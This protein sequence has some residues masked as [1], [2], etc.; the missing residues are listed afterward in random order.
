VMLVDQSPIGRTPRSNPATYVKVFDEIRRLFSSTRDAKRHNLN[1]SSFSFN[2]SG[3]RC[4]HCEG[5]GYNRV[6]MQFLAD[7]YVTCDKCNGKRFN[8]RVLDVKYKNKNINEILEMTVDEA[9]SFFHDSVRITKGL[10]FLQETGLGYLRL[11]QPATTLSG[12]EAQRL[13]IAAYMAQESADEMLFIFDEPTV[14]L[15]MDDIQKLLTC[16]QKLVEGRHSLIVVEHN[17]DIIKSADYIIDLGP[18]GGDA[19]GYIVGA[20]TPEQ[21]TQIEMSYTGRYLK[22]YF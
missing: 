2:V 16:F 17:M 3:G 14:G 15:H 9:I 8:K 5:A 6:D 7:V 22:S 13:K 20:G 11:G 4:E 12:G 10:K 1:I 18:E 21:I 19:G